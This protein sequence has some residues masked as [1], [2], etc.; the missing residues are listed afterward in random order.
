MHAG[1]SFPPLGPSALRFAVSRANMCARFVPAL[2]GV[3]M[4]TLDFRPIVPCR[5]VTMT[6]PCGPYADGSSIPIMRVFRWVRASLPLCCSLVHRYSA[7]FLLFRVQRIS[8]F[9]QMW[10]HLHC[11]CNIISYSFMRLYD[12]LMNMSTRGMVPAT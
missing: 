4:S 2:R 5:L 6:E 9:V 10:S 12:D 8:F 7:C 3:C 1:S 11:T